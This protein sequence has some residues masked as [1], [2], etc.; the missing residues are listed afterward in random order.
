MHTR[1][2]ASWS[3]AAVARTLKHVDGEPET[4]S[5]EKFAGALLKKFHG[6]V[7][8]RLRKR[9]LRERFSRRKERCGHK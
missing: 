2:P 8:R 3:Y 9:H 5:P 1:K 4:V 6:R 7:P